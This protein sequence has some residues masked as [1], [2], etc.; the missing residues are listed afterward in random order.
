MTTG[1]INQISIVW[2]RVW[3]SFPAVARKDSQIDDRVL[4]CIFFVL[5]HVISNFELPSWKGRCTLVVRW[6]LFS[7]EISLKCGDNQ[8]PISVQPS[9]SLH[10]NGSAHRAK[11]THFP[12]GDRQFFRR[13]KRK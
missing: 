12:S 4:C 1:R 3:V 13:A 8:V 11:K 9:F 5:V 6:P 7:A 2:L 10:A